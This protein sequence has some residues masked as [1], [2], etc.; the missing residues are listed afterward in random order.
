MEDIFNKKKSEIKKEE[1]LH[2]KNISEK[3]SEEKLK[4]VEKNIQIEDVVSTGSLESISNMDE[5]DE[6]PEAHE[7]DDNQKKSQAKTIIYF[8]IGIIAIIGI[9]VAFNYLAD[10]FYDDEP[11]TIDE[12]H[13]ANI[14]GELSSEIGYFYNGLSFVFSNTL[15]NT[16]IQHN[17]KIYDIGMHYGPREVENVT[18]YGEVN[19]SFISQKELYLVYNPYDDNLQNLN[20]GFSEMSFNLVNTFKKLPKA[21]CSQNHSA[22]EGV[23]I[24]NCSNNKENHIISFETTDE[25]AEVFLDGNCIHLR[26]REKEIIRATNRLLWW[27]YDVMEN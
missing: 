10:S 21:V 9:L 24:F 26:G 14:N 4:E 3:Q 11:L 27:W 22:C 25:D 7:I 2:E 12:M 13:E 20:V 18:L 6:H 5:E 23:P 1:K 16:K 17:N 8:L 19:D 15:W